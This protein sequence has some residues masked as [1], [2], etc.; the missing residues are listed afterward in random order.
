MADSAKYTFTYVG[1]GLL[2]F[3][4]VEIAEFANFSNF[5]ISDFSNKFSF[6][7]FLFWNF[8]IF[9]LG[10]NLATCMGRTMHCTYTALRMTRSA[11]PQAQ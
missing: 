11:P 7:H 9:A 2:Q 1:L 4:F 8:L 10:I 3:I 5:P 6:G